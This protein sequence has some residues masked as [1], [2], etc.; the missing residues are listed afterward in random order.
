[1]R[2]NLNKKLSVV[3]LSLSLSLSAE[4]PFIKT[5]FVFP[6]QRG[7]IVT[8]EA[9]ETEDRGFESRQIVGLIQIESERGDLR[10]AQSALHPP[11]EQ[12]TRVRIPP[13]YMFFWKS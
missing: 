6:S 8:A 5:K 3:R 4:N 1:L 12:K 13:G 7:A 10:K 9:V 2:F 11:Q